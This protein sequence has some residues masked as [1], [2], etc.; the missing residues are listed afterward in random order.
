MTSL[1]L[2]NLTLLTAD[3]ILLCTKKPD[4][5]HFLAFWLRPKCC[6]SIE[7][8]S[9]KHLFP[10]NVT[11]YFSLHEEIII[12]CNDIILLFLLDYESIFLLEFSYT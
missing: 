5:N 12:S 1:L 10:Y 4:P 9:N 6:Y 11:F 2:T 8:K 3:E 7:P